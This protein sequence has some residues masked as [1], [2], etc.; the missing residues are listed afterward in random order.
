MGISTHAGE[1]A[2]PRVLVVDD[3]PA[4]RESLQIMLESMGCEVSCAAD[5]ERAVSLFIQHSFDLVTVDYRMPG[6][7]GAEL[8]RLL[9]QEFGTGK[10]VLDAIPVRLPPILFVTAY[11]DEPAVR[12]ARLG[13][14]VVGVVEKP[15]SLATL[16]TVVGLALRAS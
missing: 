9:S 13:E 2:W 4:V 1:S 14:G 8:V 3:E 6:L 12:E 16:K 5:G 15:C 11:P 10:R 7:D